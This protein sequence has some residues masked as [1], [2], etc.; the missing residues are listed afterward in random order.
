MTVA[1]SKFTLPQ[2][3]LTLD[4]RTYERALSCVHCGLCL[5]ACPTYAVTGHEGDSP[6]GR[7]QMIKAMADGTLAFDADVGAHLDLC[8]DCRSC[9]TACPSEVVYHELIEEARQRLPATIGPVLAGDGRLM[10]WFLLNVMTRPVRLKVALLPARVLQRLGVW[11]LARRLVGGLGGFGKLAGMLPE[12]GSLWPRDPK[13]VSSVTQGATRMKVAYFGTCTGTNLFNKVN[14]CSVELLNKLGAEVHYPPGQGCCGAIHHHN[15]DEA[16]ARELARKNIN[17][18]EAVG[19]DYVVCS[20][21]GCGAQLREYAH[22][23]RDDAAFAARA[24]AFVRKVRDVTEVVKGL[25]LPEGMAAASGAE[26]VG[27][28]HAPCHLVHAQKVAGA[29]MELLAKVPGLR[30]VAL[31]EREM[32][33]GA[34]GTYN[35]T[36]PGMARELGERKVGHILRTGAGVC[37]T[38][39]AGCA[40]HIVAVSRAMG[41]EVRVVHPVEI[42][43]AAVCG[44]GMRE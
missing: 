34:A 43:H 26:V 21:A 12:D 14:G 41:R 30:M 19:A 3:S 37:V 38:G 22:L 11:K 9:E 27:T 18:M 39:N 16:T 28:Y 1:E 32:C 8:L 15:R 4:P 10:R 24:A 6:R 42:L 5:P 36:Q 44:A 35:L 33:C 17:A 13:A 7:I 25:G 29:P 2:S 31:V 40:L 23:L 20:V